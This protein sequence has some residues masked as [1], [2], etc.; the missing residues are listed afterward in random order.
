MTRAYRAYFEGICISLVI[1][2]TGV[3]ASPATAATGNGGAVAIPGA[4]GSIGVPVADLQ[5]MR[6]R[7]VVRQRYDFSCGSAALATLLTYHYG[8]PTTEKETFSHMY[9]LGD[10]QRIQAQGFSLLDMKRYLDSRGIPSDGFRIP[11]AALEEL[12]V[13]AIALVEIDGYR[14][15]VVIKGVDDG[16]VLVGDPALGL[17]TYGK[18]EFETLRT[19]DI[20]FL[21]RDRVDTARE[22]FNP[23]AAWTAVTPPPFDTA[24]ERESLAG[25]LLTLPRPSDW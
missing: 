11:L 3:S 2:L 23:P 16:R 5:S 4:V 1:L 22:R 12:G 14:H 13:P 6:F 20:L 8:L 21:I 17:K 7:S 15:F 25:F 24:L 18:R 9:E 10:P 19:N